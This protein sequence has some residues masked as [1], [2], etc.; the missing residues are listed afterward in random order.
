MS[1]PMDVNAAE[2]AD[3]E[4]AFLK[5]AEGVELVTKSPSLAAA[6]HLLCLYGDNGMAPD[7]E[8]VELAQMTARP[9]ELKKV[10]VDVGYWQDT[11]LFIP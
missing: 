9:G 2:W 4:T 11:I 8:F 10:E 5:A 6:A 7:E 3:W 1:L